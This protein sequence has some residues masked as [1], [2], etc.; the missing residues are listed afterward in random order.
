MQAFPNQKDLFLYQSFGKS[1]ARIHPFQ[2]HSA[3]PSLTSFTGGG[4]GSQTRRCFIDSTNILLRP[5]E[6]SKQNPLSV[7]GLCWSC[8][9]RLFQRGNSGWCRSPAGPACSQD[10][11]RSSACLTPHEGMWIVN[12]LTVSC[13]RYQ[14]C[15][16]YLEGAQVSLFPRLGFLTLQLRT[17]RKET[18]PEQSLLFSRER[19]C[20]F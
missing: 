4:R 15:L 8:P 2:R 7:S 12:L 1:R 18:Q 19:S 20:Y 11:E 16:R 13:C 6:L 3:A 17:P 14:L 5:R 10:G 9:R